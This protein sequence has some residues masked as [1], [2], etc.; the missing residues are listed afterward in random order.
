RVEASEALGEQRLL[1]QPNE[2]L[3]PVG[4][5]PFAATGRGEH[6][7]DAHLEVARA[8]VFGLALAAGFVAV[9]RAAGLAVFDATFAGLAVEVVFLR[10]FAEPL[11]PDPTRTPS[12]HS[13]ASSSSMSLAYISSLARIFLALTNICFSPVDRPFSTSRNER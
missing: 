4:A 2:G 12:S 11:V 8:F 5:E 1:A 13:A 6:G 7:P 10:P 9:L 3:R